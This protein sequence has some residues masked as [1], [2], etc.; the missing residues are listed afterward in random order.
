MSWPLPNDYNETIQHPPNAFDDSALRSCLPECNQLGLPKP[1]S[2]AFAVAYKLQS[3]PRNW[4]V[5][6]FT[7]QPPQD[8][9]QRYAAIGAYLSKQ[10]CP[11]ILDFTYL[12]RGIRVQGQWY[13]IVKMEWAEGDPLHI[14]VQKNL[15]NPRALTNLA[16]QWVEMISVLQRAHI[17]HGDLQHGNVLVVNSTL[18]LVDYD[19]MFVPALAGKHSAEL[20]Q[21]NYQ[22][23]QRSELDFGPYLDN[24]SA[25]VIYVSLV[26][27][28]I[29]PN[30]WQAYG[31]GDDCLL[32]R[33]HDFEDPDH[34]PLMRAL[35]HSG[36][37]QLRDLVECFKI[38]LYSPPSDTPGFDNAAPVAPVQTMVASAPSWL[39]DHIASRPGAAQPRPGPESQHSRDPSWVLDFIATPGPPAEFATEV[40]RLRM[41]AYASVIASFA[42]IFLGLTPI[43]VIA[44]FGF[45]GVLLAC[46]RQYR[47]EPVVAL[48]AQ[49]AATLRDA[50]HELN[51]AR[52]ALNAVE[53]RKRALS[54]AEAEQVQNL[55]K[56]LQGV[57]ADE[58][59]QRDSADRVLQ[60]A[61]AGAVRE[62][63]RLDQE[64]SGQLKQLQ[65]TL[66]ASI[67]SLA[68]RL[69]QV[70]QDET[71]E[72]ATT[73]TAR[74]DQ[75]IQN[76]LQTLALTPRSIPGIGAFVVNNLIASGIRT[77]A[78]CDN[79]KYQKIRSVGARRVTAILDWRQSMENAARQTMPTA[80]IPAEDRAIRA[81]YMSSRAQLQSQLASTQASLASQQALTQNKY[82]AARA[83]LEFEIAAAR[84]KNSSDTFRIE[85]DSKKRRDAL[86]EA[87]L[88]AHQHTAHAVSELEKPARSL[89][90]AVQTAQ[91]RLAK[92][93]A[94]NGKFRLITF[95][96]FLRKV[97][98]GR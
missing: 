43:A 38:A 54:S 95:R 89:R 97:L 15:G 84:A 72:L 24:F 90:T 1:R 44:G 87:I 55:T 5:K 73:L 79:L 48:K 53:V 64:E 62:K 3:R 83:P 65:G 23:P 88:R 70:Q 10:R 60:N 9:E 81:K 34:S 86:Q 20:G 21:P 68:Q 57:Q 2:G 66:G 39:E 12:Q 8:S 13:P 80:L 11:Y 49:S 18:K 30:L 94:E 17:A 28:S 7:R 96:R 67:A 40:L 4:A 6:C 37:Q 71:T 29:Y 45:V 59:T 56:Q 31:G 27:L 26:A 63:Q 78:D 85:S 46:L 69:R 14:Y 98:I 91:W 74:Q 19:G 82:A 33:K 51:S 77:A 25:W 35:R 52:E 32:F 92:A 61:I 58:K 75:H 93:R 41:L 50:E 22:H 16:L 76:H 42:T 36:N 47:T